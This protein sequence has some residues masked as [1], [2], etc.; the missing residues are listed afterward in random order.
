MAYAI[1]LRT[2]SEALRVVT[3]L[4]SSL[5]HSRFTVGSVETVRRPRKGIEVRLFTIRL[6]TSKDYCGNHPGPC[7]V[8]GGRHAKHKYLEGLDWVSFNDMVNDLLD[9]LDLEADVRSSTCWIR[10]GGK[11]RVSYGMFTGLFGHVDWK[12]DGDLSEYR[13]C[14]LKDAPQTEYPSGTPGILGWHIWHTET[15]TEVA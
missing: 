13:D 6:K 4:Y 11:R 10:K 15:T 7:R 12:H 14:R 2:E 5:D 8:T 1:T 3:A 9:R